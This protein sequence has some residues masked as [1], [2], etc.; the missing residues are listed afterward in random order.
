[1][2]CFEYLYAKCV[3]CFRLCTTSYFKHW[4]R[5]FNKFERN[6]FEKTEKWFA[7]NIRCE[8]VSL[9]DAVTLIYK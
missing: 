6:F 3:L 1:M 8:T 7:D 2:L 5:K 9:A 4:P